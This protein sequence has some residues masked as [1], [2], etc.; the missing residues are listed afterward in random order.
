MNFR[1][2]ITSGELEVH[3]PNSSSPLVITSSRVHDFNGTQHKP[4][5]KSK[6]NL[7]LRYKDWAMQ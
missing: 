1:H 7:V 6:H 5:P 3:E 4:T 2:L